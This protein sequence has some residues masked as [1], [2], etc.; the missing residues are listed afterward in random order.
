MA[1]LELRAQADAAGMRP[2]EYA[3]VR[4]DLGC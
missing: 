4:N 1:G 3:Q 2:L